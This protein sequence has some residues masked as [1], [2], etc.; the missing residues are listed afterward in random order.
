MFLLQQLQVTLLQGLLNWHQ[1]LSIKEFSEVV[2]GVE[3]TGLC[4]EH[5]S[6]QIILHV[7]LCSSGGAETDRA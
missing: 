7:K 3:Q 1:A 6:L 4:C 5:E 2:C